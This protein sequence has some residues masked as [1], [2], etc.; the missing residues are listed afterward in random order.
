MKSRFS[1]FYYQQALA[2]AENAHL[3]YFEA[4]RQGRMKDAAQYLQLEKDHRIE[5]ERFHRELSE[6]AA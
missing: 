3:D 4:L 1:Y 5:V 6:D 2:D